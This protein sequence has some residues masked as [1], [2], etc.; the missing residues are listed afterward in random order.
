MLEEGAQITAFAAGAVPR[1]MLGHVTSGY[2]S[3]ALN[4]S[5]ALA[6][7][8]NGRSMLGSTLYVPMADR[9]HAV[10]LTSP[11]FYDPQAGRLHG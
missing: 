7:V 9:A 1:P 2:F 3:P 4:R 10:R 6:L 8:A 5:I 11:V